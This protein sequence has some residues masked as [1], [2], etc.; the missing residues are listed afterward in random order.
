[1]LRAGQTKEG[2]AELLKAQKQ[3]PA[4]PHTWFNLGIVFKKDG[5]YQ[6]AIE[7]PRCSHRRPGDDHDPIARLEIVGHRFGPEPSH[8]DLAFRIL[9]AREENVATELSVDADRLHP[10]EDAVA[11]ALEHEVLAI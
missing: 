2:M 8:V 9:D 1:L 3:D 10:L 7:Q 4:I 6:H 5:D 11:C